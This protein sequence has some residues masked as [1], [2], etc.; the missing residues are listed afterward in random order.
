[1]HITKIFLHK[2]GKV[3]VGCQPRSTLFMCVG[4]PLYERR[5]KSAHFTDEGRGRK[6]AGAMS[7]HTA[8]EGPS[9][10]LCARPAT[11]GPSPLGCSDRAWASSPP[12]AGVTRDVLRSEVQTGTHVMCRKPSC[13]GVTP[14][15]P[16]VVGKR[17]I[18]PTLQSPHL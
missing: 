17:L 6:E 2:D 11:V 1:M 13:F 3:Y 12:S 7:S 15:S 16:G 5:V 8:G 18:L 4:V 9:G 10:L 14:S